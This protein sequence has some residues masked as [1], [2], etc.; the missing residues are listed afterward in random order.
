MKGRIRRLLTGLL[1]L[2]GIGLVL[3]P[4]VR[5]LAAGWQSAARIGEVQSR[6]EE[7]QTAGTA[8][9]AQQEEEDPLYREMQAYNRQIYTDRQSGLRDAWSYEEPPFDLSEYGL[10]DDAV[11][12]LTIDAM[13]LELPLYLG[14]SRDHLARGAAVL[15]NTSMPIGGQDTNCV[16]AGHRGWQGIPM[17]LEIENLQPGDL[18]RLDTLWETL[19]YEVSETRIISP[20]EIDAVKIQEGQDLLT[21]VTCHPYPH[22]YQRYLV[23]C[24]RVTPGTETPVDRETAPADREPPR[25]AS[26]QTIDRDKWI[27]R[28]ALAALALALL[29]AAARRLFRRRAGKH[30]AR[31]K[32]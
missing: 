5:R 12:Y 20:D 25:D 7:M 21:L 28:L 16:I 8:S 19:W 23:Y 9:P 14:A 30:A 3:Y 6:R 31:K 22:N 24:R 18:V 11:G 26:Q 10:T 29:A 1:A 13:D 32:R 15:G 2:A 27:N 17:F 4:N